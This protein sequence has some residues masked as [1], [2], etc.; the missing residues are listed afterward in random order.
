MVAAVSVMAVVMVTMMVSMS[1]LWDV[2]MVVPVIM[3]KIDRSSANT[4]AMTMLVPVF[5]VFG[6]HMHVN[7]G[8]CVCAGVGQHGLVVDQVRCRIP[9]KVYT[10][11]KAG[12]A[13]TDG[14]TSTMG[15]SGCR[16]TAEQDGDQ[17]FHFAY[18]A[19]CVAAHQAISES[20][21]F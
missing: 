14:Y 2:D 1:V 7:R 20:Q 15:M 11:I 19:W 6:M 16:Q 17:V 8:G 10:A 3:D 13:D 21:W 4:I 18:I 9:T 12:M 5:A